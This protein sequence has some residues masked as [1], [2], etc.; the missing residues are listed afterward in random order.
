MVLG[1]FVVMYNSVCFVF[2]SLL[3]DMLKCVPLP[4]VTFLWLNVSDKKYVLLGHLFINRGIIIE[5][6]LN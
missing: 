4:S 6:C 3:S 5:F 1:T 2:L